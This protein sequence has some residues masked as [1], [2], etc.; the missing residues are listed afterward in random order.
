[1]GTNDCLVKLAKFADYVLGA[2]LRS[3][4][5]HIAWFMVPSQVS[6]E[7]RTDTITYK[8]IFS[9]NEANYSVPL[10]AAP[11][12]KI[13]FYFKLC[14]IS[15]MTGSN[16]KFGT[17]CIEL[18]FIQTLKQP[19]TTLK[20]CYLLGSKECS[21]EN[22][23]SNHAQSGGLV[24]NSTCHWSSCDPRDLPTHLSGSSGILLPSVPWKV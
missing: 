6:Y 20:I 22:R 2:W 24:F 21:P 23:R 13:L 18:R 11:R 17:M 14:P 4:H 9:G 5:N 19:R 10:K 16:L 3:R 1:M 7:C 8:I 12:K 15:A